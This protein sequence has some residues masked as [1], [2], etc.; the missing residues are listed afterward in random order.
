[1]HRVYEKIIDGAYFDQYSTGI[2][3]I[4]ESRIPYIKIADIF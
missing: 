4:F 3:V 2:L 1:M